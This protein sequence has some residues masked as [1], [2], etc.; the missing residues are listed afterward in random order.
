VIDVCACPGGKSFGAAIAMTDVG[1]ILS[2]DLHESKLPLIREGAERLRLSSINAQMQDATNARED[3]F[4]S[5]DRVIADVPCSGLGVLR[6]KPDLRYKTKES[7]ADLPELGYRILSESARYVRRGGTL[8]FSTCTTRKEENEEVLYRFLL[9]HPDFHLT[10]FSDGEQTYAQG[11]C[12]TYTHLDGCDGFF[13]AK[14]MR[15]PS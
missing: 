13:I 10:P 11:I 2:F 4:E 15:D 7:V 12:K 14:M 6:K 1:E 8:V 5:A 3:L 9:E